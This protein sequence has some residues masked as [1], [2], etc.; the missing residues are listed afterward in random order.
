MPSNAIDE[1]VA[2]TDKAE[3][4]VQSTISPFTMLI[5]GPL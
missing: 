3:A 2:D 5:K 4:P 1:R